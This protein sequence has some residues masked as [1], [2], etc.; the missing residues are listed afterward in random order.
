MMSRVRDAMS[1]ILDN[2]SVAD[3]I[4][5]HGGSAKVFHLTNVARPPVSQRRRDKI[6]ERPIKNGPRL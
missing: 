1:D 5:A 2:M 6:A 3:L 4:A